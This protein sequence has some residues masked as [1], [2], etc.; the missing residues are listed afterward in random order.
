MYAS[1][2]T[3]SV[4]GRRMRSFRSIRCSSRSS[5]ATGFSTATTSSLP[6]AT[7]ASDT[8]PSIRVELDVRTPRG[9]GVTAIG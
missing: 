6:R 7:S 5:V 1:A 9:P 4:R 8:S 3:M 2:P